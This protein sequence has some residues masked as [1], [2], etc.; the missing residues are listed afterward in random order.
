MHRRPYCF[1][2]LSKYSASVVLARYLLLSSLSAQ[3]SSFVQ[4]YH[5]IMCSV[6]SLLILLWVSLWQVKW[7][8]IFSR[9]AR[10]VVTGKTAKILLRKIHK[11]NVW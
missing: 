6:R 3:I 11:V 8:G 2:Q 1:T 4:G 5:L 7:G 9:K 10:P